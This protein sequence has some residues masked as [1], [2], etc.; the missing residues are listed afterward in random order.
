[1]AASL[2]IRE[3]SIHR[4]AIP[5]RLRF[6]HAAA[7]R[8]TADPV[9]LQLTPELPFARDGFGETLARTY[10]TGETAETVIDDIEHIFSRLL[11]DFRAESFAETLEFMDA[12]PHFVEGRL[13][14]AARTAV[15]LA[16]LDL[17][18]AAFDR[19]AA[20][21]AGWLDI[22]GFEPPGAIATARAT[23]MVVGRKPG[24]AKLLTRLQRLYG[25]RDFKLK[26]AVD[27]WEHRLR[28]AHAALGGAIRAGRAMLRVDAN[29][30]WTL[31]EAFAALPQLAANSVTG[32]EQPLRRSDDEHLINL[33]ETASEHGIT[34]IADESLLTIEDARRLIEQEA[35]GSFNI[36]L[37]KHGG[38]LPALRIAD[39][40]LRAGRAVQLGCL[41]GQT[42]ILTAAEMA[43]LSLCPRVTSTESGYGSWL[44]RG[45]VVRRRV[46]FGLGGRFHPRT[47]AGLGV[48][49]EPA[50]LERF[51]SE[52]P[53][54]VRF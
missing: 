45:D 50:T 31:E 47:G 24:K 19:P 33:A 7:S 44:A 22:P 16:L 38:L 10:V 49:V 23:G 17:A 11:L 27:G 52:P 30:G 3:L 39:E 1:M 54:R 37:A 2:R 34:I 13:I 20:A 36:R 32:F 4:L 14:N 51:A 43:F 15:E 29:A 40:V 6:E 21:I 35:I 41:V 18:G 42:S 46:A 9:V 53:R 12:L 5:M 25:L 48:S 8:A 28:A 26:V